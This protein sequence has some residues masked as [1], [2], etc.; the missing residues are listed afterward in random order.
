MIEWE[1]EDKVPTEFLFS[2]LQISGTGRGGRNEEVFGDLRIFKK[3][4]FK[5]S[6]ELLKMLNP[7]CKLE[8]GLESGWRRPEAGKIIPY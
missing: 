5:M 6:E 1:N 4:N 7:I 8:A 3:K 2:K